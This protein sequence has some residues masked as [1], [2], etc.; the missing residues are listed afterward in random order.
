MPRPG[1]V[2]DVDRSTPPTLFWHGE[3]FSLEKLPGR[4][5]PG[6]LRRPSRC[7][8]STTS[9]ARSATPCSTRSTRTRCRRCCSRA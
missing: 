9:T 5:Q 6:D 4:P 1:F 7:R 2:L 3:G 8:R